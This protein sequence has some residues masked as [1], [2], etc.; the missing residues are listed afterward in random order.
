MRPVQ[1]LPEAE[2]DLIETFAWYDAQ[3]AGLGAEFLDAVGELLASIGRAPRLY[4]V[5]VR[6]THRARMRR[7]PYGILFAMEP[8]GILV[9]GIFH[10]R[11]DPRRWSDRVRDREAPS[12]QSFGR[13]LA[14]GAGRHS[15]PR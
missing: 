11:R 7:F 2:A 10:S 1:F 14:A 5:V 9:T 13:P 12:D 6:R 8:D 15:I 4:P 3:R